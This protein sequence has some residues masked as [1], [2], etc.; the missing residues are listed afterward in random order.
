M[1]GGGPQVAPT[2][3]PHVSVLVSTYQRAHLLPALVAAL[4]AQVDAPGLE[5]VVVDNGS[6]DAT[7]E[8]LASLASGT[9]L[10]LRVVTL[11][12]NRGPA[13]GRNAALAAARGR[14]VAFTDDDCLPS[15]SWL[16][17]GLAAL[18]RPGVCCV[19]GQVQPPD[20]ELPGPFSRV[21]RVED[22]RYFQTAN[23]LYR[24][25]DVRAVGGFDPSFRDAAGE[26]TDL[27]LRVVAHTGGR[28]V[29]APDALVHHP[30]SPSDWRASVRTAARWADLALVVRRH[31]DAVRPLLH[32]GVFWKPT[33]P[34]TLLALASLCAAPV[35][36][37]AAVGTLPWV[38][39]RLRRRPLS[40]SRK[41]R[42]RTLPAAFLVD[43][44][45][46]VTMLRGSVRHRTLLL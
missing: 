35:W 17:A 39:L 36:P 32:R 45:E 25:E 1:T 3:S 15:P 38:D 10:D 18:G 37:V 12:R 29:Y 43:A 22:A 14:V 44:T 31:H 26:D 13:G 41:E 7:P 27:G 4:E 40:G 23:V 34:H 19:V 42:L 20:G 24:T 11:D 28:A 6:T 30:V 16:A 2:G 9:P 8:V 21:L 33:H 46:V 5:V